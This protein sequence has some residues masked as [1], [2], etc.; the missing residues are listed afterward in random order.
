[1]MRI[2]RL[3]VLATACAALSLLGGTASAATPE[4]N[5]KLHVFATPTSFSAADT[6]ECESRLQPILYVSP[7]DEY[8]VTVTNAGSVTDSTTIVLNDTVP[9]GL[10]IVGIQAQ[11]NVFAGPPTQLTGDCK[12]EAA[13]AVHCKFPVHLAPDEALELLIATHVSEA[14]VSGEANTATLSGGG[15]PSKEVVEDDV[16]DEPPLFGLSAFEPNI[17]GLDGNLDTTAGDHPYEYTTRLDLEN[18]DRLSPPSLFQADSVHDV[19]DVIVDLPPGLI[20]AATATPYCTF[21][22]LSSLAGCPLDTRVGRILSEPLSNASVNGGLYNMVPEAG[23]PAE[24]GFQDLLDNVHVIYASVVPTPSGYITRATTRETPQIPLDDVIVTFYGNP[25]AKNAG[26]VAPPMFTNPADCDGQ[27]LITH[28]YMDSW[29]EPGSYNAD[30]SPNLADPNWVSAT[31]ESPPVT[32]CSELQFDP[33]I[34]A[35]PE[36]SEA[37]TPTGLDVNI[38]VPQQDTAETLGTPPLK[39]AVVTLPE[40][41]TVNPSSANGLGA[42][43]LEQIGMSAVGVP[44]AAP[45]TCPESSKIGTVEL[46]TPALPS[47]V[48]TD[49][50]KNLTECPEDEREK[51][52]LRGSIYVAR[53]TENPFGSLLAIYLVIDDPRTGIVVK[54]AGEV[55][56]NETTGQLTTVVSDSP[57][58]PFSEL[59]THF[60]G[61]ASASLRTPPTCGTYKLTSTLTPWSA[62]ESGPAA[63]PSSSFAIATG[64]GGGTCAQPNSPAFEA[65]TEAP[66][67][68]AFSPLTVHLGREDGSQNFSQIDVTLPPG[69]TGRIAGIPQCSDAQIAA[70]EARG[71][72]GEGAAELASPSCPAD[73][74]IGTVTVGAGA[75]PH[76]FYVTGNAY[77]AGPYKGAPFSAVFITPAIAGPF[78]LGVV[79]VRAGL[80]IDPATAQVTTKSDPLPTILH[81]IPLDIRSVTV[82]VNRP[83]FTLNPTNCTPMTVTGTETSTQGQSAPLSARFQVGGCGTLPFK[84]VLTASAGGKGSKANGTSLKVNVS[85]AGLGQA[86]IAKVDLTLPAALPSRLSTIQ[87]ACLASVF[88][89]NPASCDEGSMIGMATIRTPLLDS[90]LSGPG[91]LVSHGGAAFPD[92]EFVLQG[93]NV[94]LI[95]DGHT[96]IKKGIT[97]SRFDS[98]PDAP[99]TTFEALLPAGPHS[100]LTAD[101][102]EREDFSLCKT[103]LSMA[104]E[105]TGQNGAVIKQSTH[106]PTTGCPKLTTLTRAQSLAK[107][108]KA[109]KKDKRKAKRAACESQARRKFGPAKAHK[110]AKHGTAP[111]KP[112]K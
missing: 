9:P 12:V 52:P 81:G 37:D 31:S 10:K 105:I 50:S 107:A 60:F 8:Q 44:N 29:Q 61:G 93:E 7:C 39:D 75:G 104:T 73:S 43:S 17:T 79:V 49:I 35:T 76:P 68:G 67:A 111:G 84:P 91:Y 4:P 55:K 3:A 20:G 64:A 25:A 47:E 110:T 66:A 13:V 59:R 63:T 74:A 102:P 57:Q 92:V 38:D 1:M 46:E 5:L 90:P 94:K 48:C 36:K 58:F 21:A 71:N 24:F 41:M 56:A 23:V 70:A 97:Y 19:R 51:A 53:Q 15:S 82:K 96:D 83:G 108:L 26:P 42:C 2:C 112:R 86:N 72:L 62:P 32:G 106:I 6:A 88:E 45:P 69:A 98:T 18:V 22:Q 34:S 14:A 30:G 87:K 85:S 103:S 78:D 89:A 27:P 95:L 80:Y 11:Q 54:L 101:V 100:A 77:L 40:G 28:I 65:G 99:F 109:C 33:T 16:L